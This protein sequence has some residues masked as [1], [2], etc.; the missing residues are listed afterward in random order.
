MLLVV[1]DFV[2]EF[3][4]QRSKIVVLTFFTYAAL[5]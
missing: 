4:Y 1:A 2:T 3:V 5:C